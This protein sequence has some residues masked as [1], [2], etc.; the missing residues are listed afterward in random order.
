MPI[1]IPKVK[2]IFYKIFLYIEYSTATVR[3]YIKRLKFKSVIRVPG[4]TP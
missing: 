4:C 3:N 2:L 1:L